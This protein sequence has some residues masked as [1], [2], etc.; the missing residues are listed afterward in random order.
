MTLKVQVNINRIIQAL[1]LFLFCSFV[2]LE[3]YSWGRYVMLG[4]TAAIFALTAVRDRFKYKLV[5]NFY[6]LILA[7]FS[8][9][10]LISALWSIDASDALY[11]AKSIAEILLVV[12]V[13]YNSQYDNKNSVTD[14]LALIKWAS[15]II[16]IYSIFFYGIDNL[17]V[18]VRNEARIDNSYTNVNTIGMLAAIGMLIQIDEIICKKKFLF[19]ALLCIPSLFMIAV[20]QS[21]KAML[22]LFG[23][24]ILNII[25]RNIYSKDFRKT[26]IRISIC[27]VV[28]IVGL[29]IVLSL[30]MF[31]GVLERME[32]MIASFTGEG[33]SD[34]SARVRNQMVQVGLVQFT[35]TPI[36]GVGIGNAHHIALKEVGLD[37]YLHNNFVELLVGG[38]IIGF[39]IYYSM[40]VYLIACFIRYRDFKNKEYYICLVIMLLLLMMDYGMVSYYN[41]LRYI[42]LLVFFLETD[43]LKANYRSIGIEKQVA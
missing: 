29:N 33:I 11:K 22:M 7:S 24:I 19:P 2:I 43:R 12:F 3:T 31:S 32:A 28:L 30:P 16:V 15:Y 27:L 1:T 9:Y 25:F 6:I 10:A 14:F 39:V 8:L 36:I 4:C 18:M 17:I 41:K 26:I 42:Y 20:T 23:G 34:N 5:F 21:R 40:Y 35:K 38:G 37:T 13:L